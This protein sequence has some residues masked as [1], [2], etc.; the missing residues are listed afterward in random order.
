MSQNKL[1]FLNYDQEFKFQGLKQMRDT[2]VYTVTD[3]NYLANLT[4]SET[5]LHAGKNTSGHKHDGLDEVYMF[6]KGHGDIEIDQVR[7]SVEAGD[8]VHVKGGEFHKVFNTG[9]SDLI[10][11]AIFQKYTRPEDEAISSTKGILLAGGS[12]TRLSPYTITSSKQEAIVYSK[13]MI[14]YPLSTLMM[15]GIKDILI[16]STPVDL[17]NYEKMLGDGSDLGINIEYKVQENPGG[18]AEAFILGEDFIDNHDVALILGDNLFYGAGFTE[19]LEGAR[20]QAQNGNGVIFGYEVKDPERFG[21][22]EAQGSRI[23]SL[24]EKPQHPKSNIASVGLYFLPADCVSKAKNIKPSKRGEL[25]I[26]DVL[27]EFLSEGRLQLKELGRGFAYF[28]C[29]TI[30]SLFEA[31][32]FVRTIE[33][34]TNAKIGLIEEVAYNKGYITAEQLNKCKKYDKVE[35]GYYL[36]SIAQ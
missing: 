27:N 6:T 13:P 10:F 8:I 35:L 3:N 15:A 33:S 19:I 25:E 14:Y 22:I 4:T 5:V 16:I 1:R 12:G 21:V 18:I 9:T 7:F 26:T 11:V 29:G 17:P 20:R 32:N 34:C 24:E 2:D 36:K 31:S 23:I 30:E 28:D